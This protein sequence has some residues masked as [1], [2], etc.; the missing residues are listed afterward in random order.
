MHVYQNSSQIPF[1]NK[2]I[3]G[4][5]ELTKL[6]R[7]TDITDRTKL[8]M[9][10]EPRKCL[11]SYDYKLASSRRKSVF[12]GLHRAGIKWVNRQGRCPGRL[13][14]EVW[15][16][17]RGPVLC[18]WGVN[19]SPPAPHHRVSLA[20]EYRR[21]SHGDWPF[22]SPHRHDQQEATGRAESSVSLVRRCQLRTRKTG[23][24]KC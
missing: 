5:K 9:I 22:L 15:N 19:A 14:R 10:K 7:L 24:R 20:D 21:S 6:Q 4:L 2:D 12:F 3:S 11:Y 13:H 1:R 23:S 17:L 16:L 8:W 18:D